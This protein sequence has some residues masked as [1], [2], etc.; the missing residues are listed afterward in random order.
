MENKWTCKTLLNKI[1]SFPQLR[2]FCLILWVTTI[3]GKFFEILSEFS[4]TEIKEAAVQRCSVKKVFLEISQNSQENT[5]AKISF[6]IKLQALGLRPT[7]L[8]KKRACNFIKK[9]TLAQ[10]FSC[11][12][13]EIY[14]NT[15]LHRTPLVAASLII[16]ISQISLKYLIFRLNL[17]LTQKFVL[18]V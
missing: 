14:K 2:N 10:V 7:T 9:E 12:F 15:F 6:L 18:L 17:T 13:C 1:F 8:L 3:W 11:K 4:D 16:I 5:C